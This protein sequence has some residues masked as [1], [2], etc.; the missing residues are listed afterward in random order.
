M[1]VGRVEGDAGQVIGQGGTLIANSMYDTHCMRNS[2][3]H[4]MR[5]FLYTVKMIPPLIC[6]N[7]LLYVQ[8]DTQVYY[9][10]PLVALVLVSCQFQNRNKPSSVK[11]R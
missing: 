9:Y 11:V 3:F 8:V 2:T 7:E 6:G 4:P 5:M 10:S 1:S